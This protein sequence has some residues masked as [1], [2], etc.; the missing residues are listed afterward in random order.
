[1]DPVMVAKVA[2]KYTSDPDFQPDIIKKGSVAAAGLCKWVHAMIIYDDIAKNVA[3]KRAALAAAELSLKTAMDSLAEKQA[4]LKE[5]R[6]SLVHP[7]IS[8]QAFVH[9][10]HPSIHPSIRP[11][12]SLMGIRDAIPSVTTLTGDG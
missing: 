4:M 6:G 1:M 7:L 5:V 10:T 9:L 2:S 11:F 8:A 12:A 3:P